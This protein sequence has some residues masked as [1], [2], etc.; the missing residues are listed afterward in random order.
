MQGRGAS[1]V[2]KPYSQ[3]AFDVTCTRWA[4]V[5]FSLVVITLWAIYPALAHGTSPS[6]QIV[7]ANQNG[8]ANNGQVQLG[9]SIN[10]STN[11]I[12]STNGSRVWQL[13]G[14]GTLAPGGTG[15]G[16]AIYTPPYVMPSNPNVTITVSMAS[17]PA[18]TASYKITLVNP[19]PT[20]EWTTPPQA[21]SGAVTLVTLNGAGFVP[22]TVLTTSIGKA[23][24]TYK[25]PTS[26]TAE[27]TLPAGAA[28]NVSL[29]PKNPTPGG[30]TGAAYQMPI[31]SIRITATDP[32]G[33][34]TGTARLGV[35]VNFTTADTAA[36]TPGRVWTLQ[37]AGTL[38]PS[39]TNLANATYTPPTAMPA[40]PTV[41][42]M[43]TAYNLPALATS[44]T[45]T[46]VN[47]VPKVTSASPTQLL[48]N[49]TQTVT[50]TGSGFVPGMTVAYN[51]TTLPTTFLSYNEATVAVPVAVNAPS[52]LTLTVQNSAPGGGPGTTVT[53]SVATRLPA[54]TG[55]APLFLTPGATNAVT[56]TGTGFLSGMVILVN[57]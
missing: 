52:S 49:G 51:G 26:V 42:I 25:S 43:I 11:I 34:N 45:L 32:D 7:A 56:V 17:G 47:P 50:L 4:R 1:M 31:A 28:G 19:L 35:P 48:T 8:S 21:T 3:C 13:Q 22:G 18:L 27:I 2:C 9:V 40:N 29:T 57:G 20:V 39:G 5:F 30:G 38:S 37:G 55:V 44:Y 54:I 15:S 16:W 24:T 36:G 41:H 12:D 33:T 53:E 23:T 46:L 10:L 6:I 14:A